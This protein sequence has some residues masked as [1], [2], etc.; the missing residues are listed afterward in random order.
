MSQSICVYCS[1]SD[2][3]DEKYFTLAE[4]LGRLI[5]ERGWELI[6]GGATVGLMG[7]V[8]KVAQKNGANVVGII[9]KSLS[10]I[11]NELVDE[12]V[13]C[14]DLRERKAI[15]EERSTAF[16]ALPGGFGTLDEVAEII[17]HKQLGFH[18]HP[19]VLINGENFYGHLQAFF[20]EIISKKFAKEDFRDFYY[21]AKSAQDAVQ[22]VE[23]YV[24]PK[25]PSKWF[26][27]ER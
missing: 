19:I 23:D 11:K 26:E 17:T 18:R 2:A 7:H 5:G 22:Y 9:P 20:D 10:H 4:N 27:N 15:M 21:F 25:T 16:M 1:S 8:A 13:V 6:Y 24:Q 14:Q 3:V 12:L